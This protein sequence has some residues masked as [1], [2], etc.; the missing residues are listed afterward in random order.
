MNVENAFA[1]IPEAEIIAL[2]SG[3]MSELETDTVVTPVPASAMR[4]KKQ[5]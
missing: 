4:S 3:P 5:P 2:P 1:K